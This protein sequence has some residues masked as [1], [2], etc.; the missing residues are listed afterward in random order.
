MNNKPVYLQMTLDQS[1]HPEGFY[2][3]P[4]DAFMR[5]EILRSRRIGLNANRLHVKV[6]VP[7]KL[8]WADRLGLLIMADVPNSWGEPDAEMRQEIE[9]ALRGMIQRDFN[10][11]AIFSW[12]PFNET[13][14]LFTATSGQERPT[15]P[16]RRMGRLHLPA[17]QATRSH[18]ARRGQLAL[19][20][21][22]R[23]DGHQFLARLPAGLR[24]ARAPRPGLPATPIP[25]RR[26]ISSAAAPRAASRCST[27]SAAM[28][29]ATKAA[30]ATCDWSW[31]Y[32]IMM[33]EFRRH[34]K[35]CGWLYTEHHDVINEWNG[36][37]RYDRSEKFTGLE[38]LVPGMTLRDLHAP[39][40]I[41]P[42]GEL[43]RDVKPGEKVKVPLWASFLTDRA[44][45]RQRCGSRATADRLGTRSANGSST[46]NRPGRSSSSRG[47]PRS[48]SRSNSPCRT[49]PALAV[50]TLMLEDE[51]GTVLHR[52]FTTFLV[53]AARRLGATR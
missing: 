41:A 7:R 5:D 42:G 46:R 15:C 3:F 26:G 8:Y 22:S 45:S 33:N 49:Q 38:D 9:H 24:V 27:A 25:A 43:C 18:A 4:S 44:P 11:P 16:R 36:Y 20:P 21:R 50:L 14:G 12:V 39:F 30:P 37:Y 51:A 10:H 13:W 34:P 35:I 6:D 19:Q 28:S 47:C 53:A 31:D 48:S 1:Y 32:H 23:R 2:T 52:N 40:Y 29:G 17:G